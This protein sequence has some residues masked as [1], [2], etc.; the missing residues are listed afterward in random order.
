MPLFTSAYGFQI[1]GGTFINN[2]GDMNIHTMQLMPGLNT[3][4]VEF[5]TEGPTRE[6]IGAE[7][8]TREIGAARI[9]PY[10]MS[11]ALCD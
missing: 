8:N 11:P 2:A 4:A 5:P 6:L 10:G 7:R 1:T 3:N 9:R